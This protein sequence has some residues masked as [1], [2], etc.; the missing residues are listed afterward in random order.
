M[1]GGAREEET[2]LPACGQAGHFSNVN[3][4]QFHAFSRQTVA[5]IRVQFAAASKN[6]RL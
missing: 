6:P 4:T 2:A 1:I 5:I 3:D